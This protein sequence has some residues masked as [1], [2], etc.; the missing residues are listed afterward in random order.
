[1]NKRTFLAAATLLAVGCNGTETEPETP[2]AP[3]EPGD[4]TAHYHDLMVQVC[5]RLGYDLPDVIVLDY[6]FSPRLQA[7]F[8]RD[9]IWQHR[10]HG[11]YK[12]DPDT[13]QAYIA[14]F[15]EIARD[16]RT[17][18]L[19]HELAHAIASEHH[20]AEFRRLERDLWEAAKEAQGLPK[21]W[22]TF[23]TCAAAEGVV[24]RYKGEFGDGMGFPIAAVYG[25]TD[26]DQDGIVCER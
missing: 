2:P 9:D 1:M 16:A 26:H 25:Q 14:L 17:I 3:R 11:G 20:S 23:D 5:D 13:G 18:V 8:T 4:I 15:T 21:G 12:V 7:E 6:R 19:W 10:L 22:R 24:P